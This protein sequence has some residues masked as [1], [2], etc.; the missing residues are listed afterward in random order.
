MT[1]TTRPGN[2]GGRLLIGTFVG[3]C[4]LVTVE[5]PPA[6]V[7]LV[8]LMPRGEEAVEFDAAA[9]FALLSKLGNGWAVLCLALTLPFVRT[10]R[11]RP[12]WYAPPLALLAALTVRLVVFPPYGS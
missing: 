7:T 8:Q 4:L 9:E 6:F 11:L 10:R 12:W 5:A 1:T 2:P 3:A